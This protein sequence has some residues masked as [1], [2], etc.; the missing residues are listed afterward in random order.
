LTASDLLHDLGG[1]A[2]VGVDDLDVLGRRS[3]LVEVTGGQRRLGG[4][5]QSADQLVQWA[6]FPVGSR[7]Q[8]GGVRRA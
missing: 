4:G 3:R 8:C 1:A 5:E 7:A 2:V 6:E